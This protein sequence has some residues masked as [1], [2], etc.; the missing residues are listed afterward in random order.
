MKVCPLLEL[1]GVSPDNRGFTTDVIAQFV[2]DICLGCPLGEHCVFDSPGK[3]KK[4]DRLELERY[5][6]EK[7]YPK[8]ERETEG[9]TSSET[10]S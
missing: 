3:I 6:Q 8:S 4:S 9:G 10:E 5:Y 2:I 7:L 1:M